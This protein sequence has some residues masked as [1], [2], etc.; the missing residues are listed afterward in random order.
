MGI[1]ISSVMVEVMSQ[2]QPELDQKGHS[3]GLHTNQHGS[4]GV[5]ADNRFKNQ[6]FFMPPIL[7]KINRYLIRTEGMDSPVIMQN[8]NPASDLR[9]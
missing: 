6:R 9:C 7:R 3:E 8:E 5:Q 4:Y 2:F 1:T